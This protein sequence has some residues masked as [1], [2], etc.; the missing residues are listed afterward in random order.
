MAPSVTN[1]STMI[2]PKNRPTAP[3][4][5][6]MLA[7]SS[8][9]PRKA[10]A[11]ST[12]GAAAMEA[13]GRTRSPPHVSTAV[14]SK[15]R[16][17]LESLVSLLIAMESDGFVVRGSSSEYVLILNTPH[18]FLHYQV[19]LRKYIPTLIVVEVLLVSLLHQLQYL[20]IVVAPKY[21]T[22]VTPRCAVRHIR[23]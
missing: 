17:G 8:A 18:Q 3:V 16:S 7:G 15:G 6:G 21:C 1:H 11:G 13:K 5:P 10:A 4:P 22:L 2:G 23:R 14:G 12:R 19:V 9:G 20:Y